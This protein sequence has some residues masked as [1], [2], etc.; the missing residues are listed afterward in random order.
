M[1]QEA[2]VRG[3]NQLKYA[4]DAAAGIKWKMSIAAC[5]ITDKGACSAGVATAARATWV[6]RCLRDSPTR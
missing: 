1:V 4:E 3:G 6:C 5:E 2:K